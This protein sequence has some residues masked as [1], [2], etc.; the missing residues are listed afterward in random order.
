[1]AVPFF[2]GADMSNNIRYALGTERAKLRNRLKKSGI[3][4]CRAC[5]QWLDWEHPYLPNS[6]ELDEIYPVSKLPPQMRARA[7]VD[8]TNIQVLCRRC[9]VDKS[10]KLDWT[11]GKAVERAQAGA[12]ETS[13]SW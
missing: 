7:C 9:N 3:V 11:P 5:G 6:A 10:N 1:M 2:V 8:P 4:T 13:R 12:D